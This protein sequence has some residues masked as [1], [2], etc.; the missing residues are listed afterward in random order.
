VESVKT[1]S[2]LY[3]PVSGT[4]VETN[5]ALSSNPA[6]VNSDPYQG[7]WFFKVRMSNPSEAEALLSSK[8]YRTQIGD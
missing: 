6:L 7:G 5:P 3:S 1:A 8:A 4:V 2:D